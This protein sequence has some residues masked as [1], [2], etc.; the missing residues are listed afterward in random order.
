MKQKPRASDV[1]I[2]RT[3]GIQIT[4]LGCCILHCFAGGSSDMWTK[5]PLRE[6]PVTQKKIVGRE[7]GREVRPSLW[8]MYWTWNKHKNYAK[9]LM[10][11]MER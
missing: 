3:P 6:L 10:F 9:Y 7:E 1:H 8:F 5:E 2:N 4:I 11:C